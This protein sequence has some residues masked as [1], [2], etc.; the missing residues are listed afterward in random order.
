MNR[1]DLRFNGWG[2]RDRGHPLDPQQARWLAAA[3]GLAGLPETPAPGLDDIAIPA[4]RIEPA[5]LDALQLAAGQVTADRHER[6]F[7]ARGQSYHDLLHYRSGRLDAVPD[8]VVYPENADQTVALLRWAADNRCAV[9]PYGGGTS[10]VGGVTAA[11]G[12]QDAVLTLDTSR[13]DQVVAIDPHNRL[14]TA[15][16]GIY[17]PAL[18]RALQEA[19]VTLGHYPQSY[20][21]STLGGWIAARGAGQQSA[22]YGKAETWFASARVATADGVWS[23]EMFP[24]SAAGPRTG[25]LVCGSEGLLGVIV[26]ATVHVHRCPDHRDYR[27]FLFRSLDAGMAAARA[28]AQSGL[29]LAML[30]LSD[31]DETRFQGGFASIG[32]TRGLTEKSFRRWLAWRGYAD[33][34]CLMLV[35]FE[36]AVRDVDA[37]AR[38]ARWHVTRH[39]GQPL[40]TSPAD[41]WYQSRFEAPFLRDPLLDRG[42][43]V[44]TLETAGRWSE[45]AALYHAVRGAIIDAMGAGGI[46][47]AHISHVYH[48]GA[49]LYFTF[50]FPRDVTDPIGQWW[51]IKQAASEAIVANGGT[52]SHHH[53]VGEDHRPWIDRE[54]DR[55]S[56]ALLG[57][58]KRRLDPPGILNPGKLLPPEK[59]P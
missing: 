47:M 38:Q 13:L 11:A 22:R 14:A 50:V 34:P 23:T 55:L 57:A 18:E 54:K 3:L 32:R 5:A 19:G 35:G 58:V 56:L 42:L 16:A 28:L 21:Y 26:E 48:D 12:D 53:G 41:R 51:R 25:D 33:R 8:V 24:A 40:G 20:E 37:A 43:G 30:R 45:L 59:T 31:A 2:A 39:G 27:A 1:K 52:I 46:V 6:V 49:S 36:G 15:G 17:G 10:V 44:D 29:P 9:V 7:H 4:P